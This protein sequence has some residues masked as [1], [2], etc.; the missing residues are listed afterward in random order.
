MGDLE[1]MTEGDHYDLVGAY[2]ESG[3]TSQHR[4]NH[5]GTS[6]LIEKLKALAD[7]VH[8]DSSYVLRI[9][10]ISLQHGGPFDI[11]NKWDTP[12]ETHREGR[13]ADVDNEVETS[14]GRKQVSKKEMAEWLE[15]LDNKFSLRSEGNHY[16]VSIR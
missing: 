10:D 4:V 3:V 5:Y 8:A 6:R 13:S 14:T 15:K 2:G 16:H 1:L 7:S 11:L 9:N 12:H